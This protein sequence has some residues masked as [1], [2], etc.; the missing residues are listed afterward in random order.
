[1]SEREE[2]E[3]LEEN[4]PDDSVAR[5]LLPSRAEPR[6]GAGSSASRSLLPVPFLMAPEFR[7]EPVD[8]PTPAQPA[9]SP[10]SRLAWVGAAAAVVVVGGALWAFNDHRSQASMIAEQ[11]HQ[12]KAL[13]KTIDALNARLSVIESAR[14]HDELIELRRSVGEIRSSVVS[15]RDLSGAL[16][17]LAQRVEKLD[18]DESAKVDKLNERVDRETSAQGAELAARIDKLEKK[19]VVS[20]APAPVNPPSPPQKQSP[21]LPKVGPNVSMETTGS[22]NRPRPIL[23]GYIVLG[24]REDVAVIEGRYGERAV[25]PGDF[26]PGAGRVEGITR[27]GGSWVV[28]TEQGRIV[29]PDELY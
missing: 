7:A 11:A 1:M 25:R 23:R 21:P 28:L 13:A 22:I 17:Q 14:S 5:D 12:E 27:A 9:S 16:S 8:E 3:V 24:A 2:L 26:L 18:R 15:S 10:H 4:H 6:T 29:A 19:V 20:A